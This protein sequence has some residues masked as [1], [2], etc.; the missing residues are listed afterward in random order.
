[1]PYEAEETL[2]MRLSGE[3]A[4]GY[5]GGPN[6][7]IQLL[8]KGRQEGLSERKREVMTGAEV[9]VMQGYKT[10]GVGSQSQLEE[11]GR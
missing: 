6:V 2:K 5:P 3:G 1:M 4:L 10:R 9:R 11:A 7:I 8:T